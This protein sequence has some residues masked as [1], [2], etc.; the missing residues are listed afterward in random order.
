MRRLP[1]ILTAARLAAA[2]GVLLAFAILPRPAA[3]W[4]AALLFVG[5]ALT[6]WLDGRL[7]RAWGVESAFGRM[8]DPIADKAMAA[9]ALAALLGLYGPALWLAPPAAAILLREVVVSGLREHLGGGALAVT[10]AAKWKTTAQLGALAAMLAAGAIGAAL[11]PDLG[12]AALA[13][14]A[15]LLWYA[16][17]LTLWTGWDYLRRAQEMMAARPGAE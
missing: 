9:L 15:A 2:P 17:A 6:D 11:G 1:N 10:R 5:A 3:D 14:G 16:A 13:L 8:L 7:A 12:R 4:T